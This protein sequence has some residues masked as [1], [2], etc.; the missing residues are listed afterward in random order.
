M[1]R[2]RRPVQ[3]ALIVLPVAVI[4]GVLFA[5]VGSAQRATTTIGLP[6]CLGKPRIKPASV[7]LACGDGNFSVTNSPGQAGAKR[8][9][10]DAEPARSTTANPTAPPDTSTPI[11]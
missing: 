11:P 6:D 8:S 3:L 1:K 10:P 7:V 2:F 4:A 9:P 5:S